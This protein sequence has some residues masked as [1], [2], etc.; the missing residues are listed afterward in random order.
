MQK[1]CLI[2][3]CYNEEKRLRKKSEKEFSDFLLMHNNVYL[4]FVNDG[5]AD[6]TCNILNSFKKNEPKRVIILSLEKNS[7]KAEAVRQGVKHVS[8]LRRFDFIGY[9]D[10][11]LATPLRELAHI[12]AAF[13]RNPGCQFA[14]GSRIKRLGSTIERKVIRHITGRIFATFSSLILKLP[15]YDSQCG[16]KVFRSEVADM[17]FSD[18]F[19]AQWLFDVEVIARLR[20]RLGRNVVLG[21]T[22]EIPLNSWIDVAGSKLRMKHLIR[23]SFDLLKINLHYNRHYLVQDQGVVKEVHP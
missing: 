21:A 7:G 5:S 6:G 18:P 1:I 3:P 13:E 4:C 19:I 23:V 16:A 9:W 8:G 12:L 15:V 2:I 14:M 11:D 22:V 20:N 17:L 10:A